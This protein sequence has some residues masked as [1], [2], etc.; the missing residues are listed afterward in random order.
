MTVLTAHDMYD[1]IYPQNIPADAEYAGGYVDGNWPWAKTNP[2][3]FPKAR[4]FRFAV[5]ASDID[6]DCLDIENGNATPAQ[7]PGWATRRR[8][9]GKQPE[10]Y[11]SRLGSY[12]W[13]IVQNAFNAA[14]VAQPYYI[15]ADYNGKRDLPV[16]N[17]ITAIAHQYVDVGPYD[18]SSLS[19]TFIE[20]LGGNMTDPLS[21]QV[22][23]QGKNVDGSAQ[24][25]N[26]SLAAVV[27]WFDSNMADLTRLIQAQG[28]TISDLTIV[29]E[30]AAADIALLKGAQAPQVSGTFT[31]SG[32]GS[33]APS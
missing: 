21:V 19:D 15:I 17:G 16:L 4:I 9:L 25:G 2:N 1:A 26:T 27:E 29:M 18:K 10:V 32:S 31:I 20:L 3:M 7:A 14:K 33:V 12:G 13:Q 24:T 5:F 11:C 23:R 28:K 22:P 8:A 6:A 30:N